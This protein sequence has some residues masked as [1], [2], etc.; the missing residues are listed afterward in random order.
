MTSVS[1]GLAEVLLAGFAAGELE[2]D[3]MQAALSAVRLLTKEQQEELGTPINA[4]DRTLH[5]WIM[6]STAEL[7]FILEK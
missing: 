2:S 7:L 1:A 3:A 5:E 6:R 4:N